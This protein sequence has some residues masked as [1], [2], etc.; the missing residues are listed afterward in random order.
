MGVARVGD[1]VAAA[2]CPFV[3]G[4]AGLPPYYLAG[5]EREQAEL[6]QQFDRL[7][8]GRAP[9]SPSILYGPRGNGKNTLL[10]WTRQ[11]AVNRGINVLEL[12]TSEIR[13]AEDTRIHVPRDPTAGRT[14]LCTRLRSATQG[15]TA[16]YCRRWRPASP[17]V[18]MP[19]DTPNQS[20]VAWYDTDVSRVPPRF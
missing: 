19:S 10:N 8:R 1:R 2:E 11:L 9:H 14:T 18:V 16:L 17:D 12:R 6:E 5:R 15:V 20:T 13:T 7:S 3:P 4:F